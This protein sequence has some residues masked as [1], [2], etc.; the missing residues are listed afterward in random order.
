MDAAA[1]PVPHS[2]VDDAANAPILP[3]RASCAECGCWHALQLTQVAG[4]G[5][6]ICP[7]CTWGVDHCDESCC[8]LSDGV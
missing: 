3:S 2:R 7:R 8:D 6:A 5:T 4:G 1:T